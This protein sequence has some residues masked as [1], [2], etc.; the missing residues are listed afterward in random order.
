MGII[1]AIVVVAVVVVAVAVAAALIGVTCLRRARP[2]RKEGID[3]A[4]RK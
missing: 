1:V 3:G 4:R 2:Q